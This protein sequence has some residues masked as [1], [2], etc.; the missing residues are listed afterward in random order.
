MKLTR[1]RAW[2]FSRRIDSLLLAMGCF[3]L[4]AYFVAT[5][6]GFASAGLGIWSYRAHHPDGPSAGQANR[7]KAHARVDFSLWSEKR[8]RAYKEALG[9]KVNPPVGVLSIAAVNLDVPVYEGTDDLTLNRGAGHIAGTANLG[10]SGNTGVAAHRDGFFRGLKD[11][12][13]G[14]LVALETPQGRFLYSIDEIKIVDPDDVSVLQPRAGPTLTL[15]TC[16]P[17]YFVGDAPQRYIVQA[18][19]AKS[20][21]RTSIDL[22]SALPTPKEAIP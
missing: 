7:D 11:V 2:T 12:K 18:A 8:V 5:V 17:F 4:L 1:L 14:D 6:F 15:V 20:E 13:M 16:Y 22:R 3:L 21:P 19:L 10:V 9:L